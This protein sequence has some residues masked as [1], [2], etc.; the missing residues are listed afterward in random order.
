MNYTD[1]S[2]NDFI[3]IAVLIAQAGI[4]YYRLKKV[5]QKTDQ[6]NDLIIEFAI[7]KTTFKHHKIETDR[8]VVRIENVLQRLDD[9]L[10]GIETHAYE[11]LIKNAQAQ[12]VKH[13]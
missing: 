6:F 10:S 12:A 1:F 7:Q 4:L 5:E 9:R 3:T 13:D 11:A 8:Q 2:I